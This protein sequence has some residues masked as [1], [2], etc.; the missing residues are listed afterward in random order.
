MENFFKK[1]KDDRW[2]KKEHK[3]AM[4]KKR[5]TDGWGE[6]KKQTSENQRET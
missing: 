2:K 4:E 3:M 5:A 6:K 1:E